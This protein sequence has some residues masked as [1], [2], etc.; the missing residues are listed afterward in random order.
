MPVPGPQNGRYSCEPVGGLTSLKEF[1]SGRTQYNG[2]AQRAVDLK[3]TVKRIDGTEE[4]LTAPWA[5]LMGAAVRAKAAVK[6]KPA[7]APEPAAKAAPKPAAKPAVRAAAPAIAGLDRAMAKAAAPARPKG[8]KSARKGQPDDLKVIVG[9]GP[10][11]EKLLH[12]LGFFHFD[13]IAAWTA[14]EIAWV[15]D[16]LE[17]FKG[18]V[19]RDKWVAQAR[20]LA[21]DK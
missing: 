12:R 2:S 9:V 4:P 7:T 14:K 21:K 3:E 20:N 13:Q 15:D 19:T 16:N 11:L 18:R 10:A 17:G 6:A 1:E 5:G 8:L